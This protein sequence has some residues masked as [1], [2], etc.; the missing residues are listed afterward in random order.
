MS[1]TTTPPN[2][3]LFKSPF[4]HSTKLIPTKATTPTQKDI[5]LLATAPIRAIRLI[6]TKARPIHHLGNARR[7]VKKARARKLSKKTRLLLILAVLAILTPTIIFTIGFGATL[8]VMYNYATRGVQHVQQVQVIFSDVKSHLNELVDPNKLHAAQKELVAAEGEFERLHTS[9]VNNAFLN[10]LPIFNPQ[11]ASARSLS[12]IGADASQMGIKIIQSLLRL[13]PSFSSSALSNTSKP[14]ITPAMYA[15][16]TSTIAAILPDLNDIQAQ[17]HTLYPDSLPLSASQDALLEQVVQVMP[18]VQA[19][20]T[21]L[22][23]LRDGLGWF[24]GV[25]TPRTFLM[26]TMDRAELRP[27]GGFTGQFGELTTNGGRITPPAL[28]NIGPLEE[29]NPNSSVN[30]ASAPPPYRSWWPIPNWGLRDANLSAD[31]PTSAQIIMHQYRSEFQHQ[32]DGVIMFTPFAIEHILQITGPI[33]M[34]AYHET[35]TAQNLEQRLHYYQLDNAGIRHEEVVSHVQD[36][37]EARKI[38]TQ[39]LASALIGQVTHA[40]PGQ[41]AAIAREMF[42]DMQTKDV[43]IFLSNDQLEQYLMQNGDAAI[44]DRSTTSD[45]LYVVQ[46]NLSASKASQYVRTIIH[47]QVSLNAAGGA[48]HLM[49]L[50]LVY[51]QVG[52]VYGL[53]TYRDYVRVYVPPGS[54]F[55]WGDGFDTGV[56][57]CDAGFGT[58]PRYDAYGNGELLCPAS[59]FEPG[60]ATSMLNDPYAGSNHPLDTVGQPTNFASDEPGRAMFGGWVVIPKNCTL[61]AT[62]SWYVPPMGHAPYALLVQR[63]SA[64]FPDLDLIILP[65]LGACAAL[66]TPGMHFQ[67]VMSGVDMTFTVKPSNA[68]NCYP[69]PPL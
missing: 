15:I 68:A 41:L 43:E 36:P 42:Y 20:F 38:F 64:T 19:V 8:Y 14:L 52:P 11:I 65:A 60:A 5:S 54:Q 16:I 34:S 4:P 27:T 67:G 39:Q 35:I 50:R 7:R 30:G 31:F 63:Q 62:L 1:G 58:C 45:G 9:L 25:G 13:A 28:K 47:D 44:L 23:T 2:K 18:Q 66:H 29:N 3:K 33:T 40:P 21:Q 55:L 24:L 32:L 48:T 37:Q 10:L 49:Q 6:A 69:Q 56:P 46:A 17:T 26:E 51:A 59:Q 22:Y 61:T 12:Q 57:L 53:D